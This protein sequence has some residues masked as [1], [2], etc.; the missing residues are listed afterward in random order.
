MEH[1]PLAIAACPARRRIEL[2]PLLAVLLAPALPAPGSE[3]PPG[4]EGARAAVIGFDIS[5]LD[6]D[7]LY[8]PPDGK[9]AQSYEF[10]I[11]A[12]ARYAAEVRRIDPTADVFGASPGRIGCGP[13]QVLVIGHTHQP[14]FASVLRRLAALP[15]VERIEEAHFE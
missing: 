4:A 8:G 1:P 9:R 7:G 12:G 14:G 15:Y 6:A 13:G 3:P 11:P 5:V 10:C 2:L